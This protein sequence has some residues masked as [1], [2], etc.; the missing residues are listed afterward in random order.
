MAASA[1]LSFLPP[2][3]FE[4][5]SRAEKA[6]PL[7]SLK[8]SDYF[9]PSASRDNL[10]GVGGGRASLETGSPILRGFFPV[11]SE[12]RK[13]LTLG[14]AVDDGRKT[15]FS[16]T[17]L[18]NPTSLH[19]RGRLASPR[20]GIRDVHLHPHSHTEVTKI[21]PNSSVWVTDPDDPTYTP[22]TESVPLT[23]PRMIVAGVGYDALPVFPALKMGDEP[24]SAVPGVWIDNRFAFPVEVRVTGRTRRKHALVTATPGRMLSSG[25]FLDGRVNYSASATDYVTTRDADTTFK[26]TVAARLSPRQRVWFTDEGG[27]LAIGQ[28]LLLF[29]MTKAGPVPLM[30][31]VIS[32]QWQQSITLGVSFPSLGPSTAEW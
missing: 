20:T 29:R 11:S 12:G 14:E 32:S 6:G 17:V 2:P 9:V 8:A 23:A 19:L 21:V 7:P 15:F 5:L 18:V 26:P 28:K 16:T 30:E 1:D 25:L 22:L 27:G 24:L 10:V 31:T 4:K 3:G 13:F